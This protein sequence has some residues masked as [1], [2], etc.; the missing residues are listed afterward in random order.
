MQ[1]EV[2]ICTY[3]RPIQ[4]LNLINQIGTSSL[5][6]STI[7]VVDSSDEI[8]DELP[9]IPTVKYVR[10]S[11]KNQPYQ[12]CL[13]YLLATQE[14]I[15]FMDDD[16]VFLEGDFFR[17]ISEKIE[18]HDIA[19]ISVGIDYQSIIQKKVNTSYNSSTIFFKVVNFLS[20]VP[21]RKPGQMYY[22]GL[23]GSLP[24]EEGNVQYFQGPLM[25][26]KRA[27]LVNSF[28]FVL[29]SL[30]EK[31]LA[32]GEDK[33]ISMSVGLRNTL[34]Y[35][36]KKYFRHPTVNQEQTGDVKAQMVM[37]SCFNFL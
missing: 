18:K 11:H 9:L 13:G 31:H 23:A 27:S 32:M 37:S 21:F 30:F 28:D 4:V 1:F 22:A 19:G 12:R 5:L 34:L 33:A 6:P 25:V 8:N 35:L 10:S 15:V 7:I 24:D 29:F 3:N 2:I 26:F 36:P 17:D 14:W 16:L 20:G